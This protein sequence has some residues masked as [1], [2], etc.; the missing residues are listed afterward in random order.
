M[1]SLL[2]DFSTICTSFSKK[3]A[4]FLTCGTYTEYE[5]WSCLLHV[6][7]L[8]KAWVTHGTLRGALQS[9]YPG[10]CTDYSVHFHKTGPGFLRKASIASGLFL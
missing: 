5:K 3:E 1:V 2:N 6:I 8:P 7:V 10:K 9:V 4:I